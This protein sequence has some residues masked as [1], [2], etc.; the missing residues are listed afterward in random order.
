M[1]TSVT[2]SC[3][4]LQFTA[5]CYIEPFVKGVISG[6]AENCYPDEGGYA[7]IQK[8]WCGDDDVTFL[9]GSD[10]ADQLNDAAYHAAVEESERAAQEARAEAYADRDWDYA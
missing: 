8:L 3:F 4:G 10:L 6:P 9:L 1:S 5:D 7:E 2:F